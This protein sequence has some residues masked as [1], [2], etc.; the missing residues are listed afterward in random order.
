MYAIGV[1]GFPPKIEDIKKA[2]REMAEMGFKYIELE[3]MG[4][5]N[6]A[7]VRRDKEILKEII[8]EN[9]VQVVNFAPLIPQVISMDRNEQK[10]ALDYFK[11][12]VETAKFLGSPRVWIDS[13]NPPVEISEGKT[14]SEEISYGKP[15]C[16]KIPEGFSWQPFW[17]HFVSSIRNCNEIAKDYGLEFLIEPRV[18]EVTSNSDSLLR[19]FD[20]IPDDNL[21][22]ILDTAHQY[23][24]KELLPI[25]IEKLGE[26]IRYVHVADND[27][28]DN[29]HLPP[30]EGT[31]DW[32]G[33]FSS[34]KKI[35]YDGFYAIDLEKLPNPGEKFKQTKRALEQFSEKYNL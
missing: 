10:K 15:M 20:A 12:G 24:Q 33:V 30:G 11:M 29:R 4:Y 26:K 34:L 17:N 5:E 2:I 1:Y 3:G 35:G 19:L 22:A 31:I 18:H 7:S 25:A 8:E 14:F 28:R 13:Y 16:V 6:M 27:S 9:S 32:D 21:G 23:A